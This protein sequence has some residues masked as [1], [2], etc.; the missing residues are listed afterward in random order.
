MQRLAY[1]TLILTLI[2]FGV[3]RR[4]HAQTD[5]SVQCQTDVIVFLLDG[6]PAIQ[7]GKVQAAAAL[8]TAATLQQNQPVIRGTTYSVFALKSNELQVH[9]NTNPDETKFIV[10]AD[11]CGVLAALPEWGTG[12]V[13]IAIAEAGA[14]GSASAFAQV[15]GS[16]AV[17]VAQSSGNGSASALA[18][19][20]TGATRPAAPAIT[21]NHDG[22]FY[23]VQPGDT[24]S[25]IASATHTGELII[26]E[27]NSITS[28]FT[29]RTGQR[30]NIPCGGAALPAQ[31]CGPAV[32]YVIQE[33]DNLFRISLRYGTS[34]TVI[35]QA[36][37][38]DDPTRIAV[39]QHI[40]V[41]CNT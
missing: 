30:L 12:G 8:Q 18:Q 7:V 23:T 2:T 27:R 9:I 39:G 11:I 3:A 41:P 24:L 28:P 1:F 19:F 21:A 40:T 14:G 17:A 15:N 36:N 35:A 13:A 32:V 25:S 10:G 6:T 38:I 16:R 4:A 26:L 33:G 34:V 29:L 5:F 37:S 20:G 31:Q 22:C